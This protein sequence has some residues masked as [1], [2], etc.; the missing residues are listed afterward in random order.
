MSRQ[1][2][3]M[4]LIISIF[5]ISFCCFFIWVKADNR[6]KFRI[7]NMSAI[8]GR[9]TNVIGSSRG[10]SFTIEYNGTRYYFMPNIGYNQV[11]F[12][13]LAQIGDS[14]SKHA[15]A[16]TLFLFKRNKIYKYTFKKVK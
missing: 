1:K 2:K 8:E 14:I 6:K 3:Y 9:I 16:D 7:F 13:R 11:G 4:I 15:F 5:F 10:A 12:T